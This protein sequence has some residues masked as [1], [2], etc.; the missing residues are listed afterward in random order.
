MEE[1]RHVYRILVGKLEG[2]RRLGRPGCRLGGN[3]KMDFREI[4]W[5]CG[6]DVSG[7]G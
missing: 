7:S 2:K 6:L 3:I 1:N 5:G 4:G